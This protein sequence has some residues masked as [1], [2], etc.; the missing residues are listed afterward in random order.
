MTDEIIFKKFGELDPD[1]GKG[2]RISKINDRFIFPEWTKISPRKKMLNIKINGI[3]LNSQMVYDIFIL[4]IT[5]IDQRPKCPIC[6]KPCIYINFKSGYTKTCNS[7]SCYRES[8]RR[9]VTN[10]WSNKD[11]KEQ[12]SKS[13]K[14]WAKKEENIE[15]MRQRSINIWKNTKYREKQ[16]NVHKEWASKKENK[17]SLSKRTTKMWENDEYRKKQ[18]EVHK[19]W[20]K[21]NP[22]KIRCYNSSHGIVFSSKARKN[23]FYDSSW[24]KEVI[25]NSDYIDEIKF[26][27]RSNLI[28][29]YEFEGSIKRYFPDFRVELSN[30][31][32]ILLEI[33]AEYLMETEINKKKIEAGKIFVL[34]DD[35]DF[36]RYLIL[37][38]SD[39]F[40]DASRTKFD[41]EKFKQKLLE[42]ITN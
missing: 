39:L 1:F 41:R 8:I 17:E 12:Q 30:G 13:H 6:G 28:L 40:S 2:N 10:L 33:K 32:V 25:I 3:L 16:S 36:D 23:L 18:S 22:D 42:I 37:V 14:E 5:N 9:S 20:V 15:Y 4:G 31:N 19:E 11:Y 35:N 21:N 34:R 38:G 24:E 7:D 27:D 29:E 26:I